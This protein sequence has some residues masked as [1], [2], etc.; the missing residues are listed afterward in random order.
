V[1]YILAGLGQS[2]TPCSIYGYNLQTGAIISKGD[3]LP[4]GTADAA[5][6]E[7]GDYNEPEGIGFVDGKLAVLCTQGS[8]AGRRSN[9]IYL[10]ARKPSASEQSAAAMSRWNSA[11]AGSRYT[12]ARQ[13][14]IKSV[15]DEL[16]EN[17]IYERLSFL[18]LANS[19]SAGS[20]INLAN[21][22]QN[23]TLKGAVTFTADRGWKTDGTSGYIDTGLSPM[24]SPNVELNSA[25]FGAYI[26]GTGASSTVLGTAASSAI[27]LS[28]HTAGGNFSS[29]LNQTAAD[30]FAS[31]ATAGHFALNR[32]NAA[33]YDKYLNGALVKTVTYAA[34]TFIS[35]SNV[36]LLGANGGYADANTQLAAAHGGLSLT[37]TQMTVLYNGITRYLHELGAV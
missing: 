9:R 36:I 33:G 32:S 20:L 28:A 26:L 19:D 4:I 18:Y 25:S 24:S 1:L 31:A 16:I 29:R 5:K 34:D 3:S 8:T 12:S 35:S 30:N 37:A 11:F 27:I 17:G 6:V 2:N 10:C 14:L 13:A 15:L 21:P 7:A 23:A 22:R